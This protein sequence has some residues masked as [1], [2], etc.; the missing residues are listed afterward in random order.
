[1]AYVAGLFRAGLLRFGCLVVN[2]GIAVR[3]QLPTNAL[4]FLD[5]VYLFSDT[6]TYKP[7]F[8]CSFVF[9]MQQRKRG[10]RDWKDIAGNNF[11]DLH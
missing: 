8:F 1:M 11:I 7:P 2:F 10:S 4:C 5:F 6:L 9:S 3:L